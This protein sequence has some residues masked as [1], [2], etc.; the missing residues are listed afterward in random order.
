MVAKK[1]DVVLFSR[2]EGQLLFE[3]KPASAAKII[4]RYIY[5]SKMPIE[6]YRIADENG[7]FEFPP[8]IRKDATVNSLVQFVSHQEMVVEYEGKTYTIWGHGKMHVG[9]NSE[10][11]GRFRRVKCNINEDLNRVRL[12]NRDL[13]LTNCS[14]ED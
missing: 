11:D 14:F 1:Q 7:F 6:D 4:R 8:I 2:I 10:Y 12:D 9:E 3:R 13:V 5:D